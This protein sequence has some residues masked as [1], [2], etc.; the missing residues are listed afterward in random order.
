MTTP[1][2]V[3]GG[4]LLASSNFSLTVTLSASDIFNGQ[5]PTNRAV[6]C[7]VWASQTTLASPSS[8]TYAGN[9]MNA[10]PSGVDASL[11]AYQMFY[12]LGDANCPTGSQTSVATLTGNS[13][14]LHA[15][16]GWFPY[17]GVDPTSGSALNSSAVTGS[18]GSQS[19]TWNVSSATGNLVAACGFRDNTGHTLTGGS[20]VAID[21]DSFTGSFASLPF[22]ALDKAGAS[23]TTI[24]GSISSSGDTWAGVAFSL[25]AAGGGGQI[26]LPKR[27]P[28]LLQAVQRS[29]T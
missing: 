1:T 29:V 17:S 13:S 10:G 11:R 12:L 5:S 2:Y 20:G 9:T 21:F 25:S 3:S 8:C 27:V 24:N 7:I 4:G 15:I 18:A 19:P 16:A 28:T 26:I 22:F 14:S 23:T 6:I